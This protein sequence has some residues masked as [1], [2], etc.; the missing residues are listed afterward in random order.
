M[1][2]ILV[3]AR[4]NF[5]VVGVRGFASGSMVLVWSPFR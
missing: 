3:L 2:A 4:V 5:G 1:I